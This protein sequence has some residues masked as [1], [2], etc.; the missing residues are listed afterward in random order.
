M[1]NKSLQ[2][3]KYQCNLLENLLKSRC[4]EVQK[5]KKNLNKTRISDEDKKTLQSIYDLSIKDYSEILTIFQEYSK[6]LSND[7]Q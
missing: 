1:A 6:N 5:S 7:T 3:D 4:L 2:L